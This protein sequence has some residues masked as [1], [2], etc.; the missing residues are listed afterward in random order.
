MN[1]S[2]I[3]RKLWVGA[4]LRCPNCEQGKMFTG[5][6]TMR[7]VCPVC[8]VVFERQSGDS[9]GAMYI[10]LGVA[11]MTGLGGFFL[12]NTL[13]HPPMG[14]HIA[15]WVAY[16]IIFSALFHRHARGISV[17][18]YYLTVGLQKDDDVPA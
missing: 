3:I 4:R 8:G 9:V 16:A 1:W 6:L 13:Y 10:N 2:T 12:V 15:F 17:A 5:M 18:I 7:R 11:S 14:P